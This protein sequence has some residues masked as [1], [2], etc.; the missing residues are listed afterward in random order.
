MKLD[1]AART[2]RVRF[3]YASA[4]PEPG[5]LEALSAIVQGLPAC[6]TGMLVIEGHTDADGDAERNQ[7]LSVRRAQAVRDYLVKAGTNPERL[8]VVGFG[9]ARPELPNVSPENKQRN[10]RVTLVLEA[11]L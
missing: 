7:T 3:D 2:L 10:R 9:H 5:D 1:A 6:S 11:P 4:I 8:S